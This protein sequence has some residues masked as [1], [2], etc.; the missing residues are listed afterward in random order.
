MKTK[1]K[2]LVAG[3]VGLALLL[4]CLSVGCNNSA[5]K[6]SAIQ[7]TSAPKLNTACFCIYFLWHWAF[8]FGLGVFLVKE[9]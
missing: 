7:G 9:F 4:R 6:T 5:T 8:V 3:D 2:A 1:K